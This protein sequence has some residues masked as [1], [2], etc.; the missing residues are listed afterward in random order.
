MAGSKK[1]KGRGAVINSPAGGRFDGRLV[2]ATPAPSASLAGGD[3][4][5]DWLTRRWPVKCV[6]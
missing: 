3:D 5:S 4:G 6:D 2:F 1:S